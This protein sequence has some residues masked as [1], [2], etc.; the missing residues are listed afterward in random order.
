MMLCKICNTSIGEYDTLCPYCEL[1]DAQH[2]IDLCNFK[3]QQYIR[4]RKFHEKRRRRAIHA[5]HTSSQKS[6]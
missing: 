4:D 3:M 6:R 5:I 1:K 2:E